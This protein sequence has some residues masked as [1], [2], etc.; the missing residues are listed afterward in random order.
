MQFL[1]QHCVVV[2]VATDNVFDNNAKGCH[3]AVTALVALSHCPVMSVRTA[4]TG[5]VAVE[6]TVTMPTPVHLADNAWQEMNVLPVN[7]A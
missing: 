3:F 7:M 6:R 4:S 5:Q 2:N 1:P